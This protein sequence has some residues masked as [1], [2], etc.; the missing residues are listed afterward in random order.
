MINKLKSQRLGLLTKVVFTKLQPKVLD[1]YYRKERILDT[2]V[3]SR[4]KK[5][6]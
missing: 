5:A 1:V 2:N 4:A 3:L 6:S